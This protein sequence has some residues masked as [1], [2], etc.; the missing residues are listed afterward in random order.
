VYFQTSFSCLNETYGS[1]NQTTFYGQKEEAQD[2]FKK[3]FAIGSPI[4]TLT[5]NTITL[6]IVQSVSFLIA[7]C[8][9]YVADPKTDSFQMA[10]DIVA[11]S[12]TEEN[13]LFEN[14]SAFNESCKSGEFDQ[15]ADVALKQS[16]IKHESAELDADIAQ[17]TPFLTDTELLLGQEPKVI[18]DEKIAKKK[19]LQ[20]EAGLI[21]YGVSRALA[22]IAKLLI[23]MIRS[24][25]YFFFSTKQKMS[26]YYGTQADLIE[27]NAY[28][29]QYESG[30]DEKKKQ[31]IIAKQLKIA[32]RMRH[33]QNVF[34]VDYSVSRKN[35]EKMVAA[36]ASTK[37]T[38]DDIAR[39]DDSEE[40]DN[41][42][43]F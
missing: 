1:W 43:I 39:G 21:V 15:A 13:L 24:L 28:K 30:I 31:A 6:A 2:L 41:S 18:H 33:K 40:S 36:D 16:K 10:L 23:P 37:Y 7:T 34:S 32:Q 4:L 25:V 11:Y 35:T 3:A 22:F 5:Y 20:R 42:A 27:M 17:D 9:E 19:E 8:V 26:D 29:L 38:A 12:K 14:L